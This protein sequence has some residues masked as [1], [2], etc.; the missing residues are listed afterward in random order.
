[1]KKI[2][3]LIIPIIFI[4][5]CHKEEPIPKNPVPA[6]K[7]FQLNRVDNV[8]FTNDHGLLISGVYDN[9]YTLIKTD[10][11]LDIEWTRT[12]YEWGNIFSG[13]VWGSPYINLE[14]EM[15]KVFQQSDGKYICIGSAMR[16]GDVVLRSAIVVELNEQGEQIRKATFDRIQTLNAVQANDGGYLL[17]G[18]TKLLKIDSNY[19]KLWEM[20]IANKY[21]QT[22]M[23]P[24]A[25]GGV[26][27]T[28]S[29]LLGQIF[30]QEYDSNGNMYLNY[31]YGVASANRG[32]DLMQLNENGFLIIGRSLRYIN[33][34]NDF[35]FH[36]IRT[37]TNGDT[38]WTRTFG[39][40][41]NEWL[42]RFVSS[43]QNEFVIQGSIGFPDENQASFL[44]KLDSDGQILDS[45]S[46]E[47]FSILL[48]SPLKYYI[49]VQSVD[50]AHVNFS[51][52]E[53]DKL[54]LVGKNGAD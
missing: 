4:V 36:A 41:K 44:V 50:S 28:G 13:S 43:N 23:T 42:D 17:F 33:N 31:M 26:A 19:N 20:G 7:T 35:D 27:T 37:N 24:I 18:R 14:L 22:Q 51:T 38:I 12:N 8:Y 6:D 5:G 25:D 3:L 52:I 10:A 40:S 1:M 11:N 48:Y 34:R 45:I 54:F 15:V 16:G 47:K 53:E 49:K 32:F 46:T 29:S 9:K 30:L 21:F 39:T 2:I